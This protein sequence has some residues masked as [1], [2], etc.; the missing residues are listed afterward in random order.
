MLKVRI[1]RGEGER[2]LR[3]EAWKP[4]RRASENESTKK[5]VQKNEY[6]KNKGIVY[7]PVCVYLYQCRREP[8]CCSDVV[9]GYFFSQIWYLLLDFFMLFTL[10]YNL[11]DLR[12]HKGQN[13]KMN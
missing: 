3:D 11:R 9:V 12:V 13:R 7:V 8:V 10:P 2:L 6:K 1:H 4:A 5:R